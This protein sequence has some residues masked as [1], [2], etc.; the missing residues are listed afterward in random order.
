M[1]TNIS[2]RLH[3]NSIYVVGHVLSASIIVHTLSSYEYYLFF[4]KRSE[5][6][7]A[8]KVAKQG[9]MYNFIG[10]LRKTQLKYMNTLSSWETV[11]WFC[12]EHISW[13]EG[14]DAI[15]QSWIFSSLC[16]S[17]EDKIINCLWISSLLFSF[18]CCEYQI[19]FVYECFIFE[20]HSC[21]VVELLDD[22]FNQFGYIILVKSWSRYNNDLSTAL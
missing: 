14:D 15:I 2:H 13:Q 4:R 10:T 22:I 16:F 18:N 8:K 17:F 11:R 1:K 9:E 19:A 7:A 3:Y 5:C 12:F 20:I 21:F 6:L